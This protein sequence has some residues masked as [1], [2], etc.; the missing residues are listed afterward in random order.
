MTTTASGPPAD[1]TSNQRLTQE[2]TENDMID[3]S[4]PER[5]TDEDDR[6]RE[7]RRTKAY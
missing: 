3:I 6:E 5:G 7:A 1:P 2:H 4:R